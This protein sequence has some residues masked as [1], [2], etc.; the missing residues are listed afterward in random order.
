V[1]VSLGHSAAAAAE[2]WA[3]YAAGA[4]STT[5]LFN[6]MSG[7]EHRSPGVAVAALLEDDAYVELIADGIHVHP[8]VWP[9]ITRLKPPDRLLLVSDALAVA[10]TPDGRGRI[11]ELEVEVRDGRAT[12]AGTDTLAGSVIALDS[13]VRN[14]AAA[15]I[16]LPDAVAAASRN[17]LELLGVTDRGRLAEGQ[18]ADLVELDEELA[19]L[20]VMRAGSWVVHAD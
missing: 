14:A 2:A 12:L 3:G 1:A 11:G 20:R 7:V 18:R 5:H 4:R 9:L 13:A 8:D 17:P 19:V 10:G 15:G 16:P 6:A